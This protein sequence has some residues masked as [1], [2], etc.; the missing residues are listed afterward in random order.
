MTDQRVPHLSHLMAST[1]R[2][3]QRGHSH[4]S[5]GTVGLPVPVTSMRVCGV[6]L[7]PVTGNSVRGVLLTAAGFLAGAVFF[8]TAFFV[9][10]GFLAAAFFAD[11]GS[12]ASRRIAARGVSQTSHTRTAASLYVSQSEHCQVGPA[13]MPP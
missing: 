2:Y 12:G 6:L 11:G 8:G 10:A 9:P 7:P 1:T 4:A 5:P 13:T 3:A